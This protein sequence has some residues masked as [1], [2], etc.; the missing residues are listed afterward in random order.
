MARAQGAEQPLALLAQA[1]GLPLKALALLAEP[2]QAERLRLLQRLAEP[3]RLS[4]VSLGAEVESGPRAARKER[5]QQWF[6]L[7][8]TWSY[9][10]AACAQGLGPRYHP[11][12]ARQLEALAATVAPRTILR[13]HRTLLSDRALLSHPL[14]AR[15]VAENALAGY[16]EAV[17]KVNRA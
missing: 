15:L 14:N 8:A 6:D 9:D 11:D 13:Y 17:L 5:L 3:R 1:G 12:F 10:L 7:L 2:Y 16:R 4:V